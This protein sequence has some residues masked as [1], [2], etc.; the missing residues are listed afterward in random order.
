MGYTRR[1]NPKWPCLHVCVRERGCVSSRPT[2]C[3]PK[4]VGQRSTICKW[5]GESRGR[6]MESEWVMCS[7]V[8]TAP[9]LTSTVTIFRDHS[10]KWAEQGD[11]EGGFLAKALR[12]LNHFGIWLTHTQ[13]HSYTNNLT[14]PVC[15]CVT[16]DSGIKRLKCDTA[17][18]FSCVYIWYILFASFNSPHPLCISLINV[19]VQSHGSSARSTNNFS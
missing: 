6:E 16:E 14:V 15:T 4:N 10:M 12:G 19:I 5:G 11:R 8:L 2:Y 9:P 13:T 17:S 1:G 3:K 7:C 18:H